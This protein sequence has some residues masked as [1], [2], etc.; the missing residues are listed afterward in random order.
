MKFLSKYKKTIML[1]FKLFLVLLPTA[2]Y[3]LMLFT[4]YP[5]VRV[6]F[7][8]KGFYVLG[9]VYIV[10]FCVL[11]MTYGCFKI[12]I[13]RLRELI[14]SYFLA[15]FISNFISYL[16]MCLI[17]GQMLPMG[18][19]CILCVVQ[20]IAAAALYIAANRTYFSLYP[21]RRITVVY[22]GANEDLEV[23]KKFIQ[24]PERY[25]ICKLCLDTMP[26]DELLRAI[27]AEPAVL[28]CEI[29][30]PLREKLISYCYEH[31]KRLFLMPTMQDIMVNSAHCTQVSDSIVY[32]CKNRLM[33]TE[34]AIVKRAMDLLISGLGLVVLS[35]LM[36]LT[37]IAIKVTDRG[38]VFIRQERLTLNGKI[39]KLYK[40][41]SM[42][43]N[44]EQDGKA[45]LA[46]KDDRRITPVGRVIRRLR[47]DELPQ[48]I[49]ILQG[50]MSVVG[51]RPERPEI[52]AQYEQIFPEFKYRLKAK[53]GLTGYAQI[54]GKYNTRFEDKVKMDLLYIERYSLLLDLQ[55][56][57]GT[58][59]I[60][61]MKDSTEGV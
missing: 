54:Y 32:L 36:L 25:N 42:I 43:V 15:I 53:A 48:L 57:F 26:E 8:L 50:D 21:A 51:P 47:I 12:G 1:L 10:L 9:L 29:A 30:L 61:F 55:L 58:V 40:F 14:Y 16:Q 60:L 22:G 56:I 27:D 2:L 59:K 46:S 52:M 7:F 19:L 33:S 41:R 23:V 35:P 18:E 37:A 4:Q 11:S 38:P 24:I 44:A 31:N 34:Q 39:F 13:L 20:M 6:S 17:V 28:L 45:R 5:Q 49:N 3:M